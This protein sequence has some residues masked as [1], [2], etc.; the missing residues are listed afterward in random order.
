MNILKLLD[1]LITEENKDDIIK[2]IRDYVDN[3]KEFLDL[4]EQIQD[5]LSEFV[6]DL[7]FY[8]SDPKM[9]NEDGSLYGNE[10]L[11]EEIEVISNKL[12]KLMGID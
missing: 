12:R 5:I 10:K 11:K 2:S 1:S 7:A 9:R 4:S 6:Y 3:D 8:E